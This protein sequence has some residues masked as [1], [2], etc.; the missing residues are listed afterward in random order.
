MPRVRCSEAST[1]PGWLAATC[2]LSLLAYCLRAWRQLQLVLTVFSLLQVLY[3]TVLYCTVFSLLQL[4]APLLVQESPR[5]QLARGD[6]A[7]CLDTLERMAATNRAPVTRAELGGMLAMVAEQEGAGAGGTRGLAQQLGSLARVLGQLFSPALALQTALLMVAMFAVGLGSYGIIFAAKLS[8]MDIFL[9]TVVKAGAGLAAVL[10]CTALVSR[11]GRAPSLLL[12]YLATAAAAI[13]F[14]LSPAGGRPALYLLTGA[15]F[16]ANY[17]VL[18]TFI[19]E[20][21]PT[22]TRCRLLTMYVVES[23][24]HIL[25]TLGSTFLRLYPRYIQY[26]IISED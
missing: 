24:G 26:D 21:L 17:F 15:L 10:A 6:T 4:V 11:L 5:W 7:A 1:C 3:C 18:D 2:L 25:G 13:G 22:H 8:S 23:C 20:L 19:M 14:Y 12:L 16:S 9:V